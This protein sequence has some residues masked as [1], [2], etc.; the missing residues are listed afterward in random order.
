MTSRCLLICGAHPDDETFFAGSMAKYIGEG[1]RV[2]LLCGT[3]G[4]RGATADLC[5]IEELPCVREAELR[6]SMKILGL[7]ACDVHFLP[8]E[9]QKLA[10]APLDETRKLIVEV[11]RSARPQVVAGFDLGGNNGHPD[12]VAMS[13]L[14][15]DSLAAAG[16]PRW[17]REAGAAFAVPR[18][19]WA[20]PIRPWLLS[21]GTNLAGHEGVDFLIDTT[22]WA[23]RK[24]A[25]I[26]AHRTQLPGIKTLY[27]ERGSPEYTLHQEAFRI[28]FGPRPAVL[29]GGDLFEGV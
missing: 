5:T 29:P 9:D 2:V 15:S 21:P 7:D 24:A 12:H 25:A 20:P 1:V 14:T 4:E 23:D 26:R 6:L 17:Y 16:D 3:R 19:L 18:L 22:R 28:A 11:V 13:R 27:F 8:Y 10:D